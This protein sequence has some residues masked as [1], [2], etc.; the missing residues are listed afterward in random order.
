VKITRRQLRELINE[1]VEEFE[2]FGQGVKNLIDQPDA[3][4]SRFM[5]IDVGIGN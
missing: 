4:H 5:I 3:T 1:S 2:Y